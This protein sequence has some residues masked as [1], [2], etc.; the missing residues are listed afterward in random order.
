MSAK[1]NV[2][3]LARRDK[4][5]GHLDGLCSYIEP[6]HFNCVFVSMDLGAG[7]PTVTAHYSQD[8]MYRYATLEGIGKAPYWNAEDVLMI[9]DI[10]LMFMSST[11]SGKRIIREAWDKDWGGLSFT[12]Q[13][14]KSSKAIK[15]HLDSD[16]QFFKMLAL[17]LIYGMG[18]NRLQKQSYEQFSV[19]LTE[20]EAMSI[21]KGYWSTFAGVR[22]LVQKMA[23]KAKQGF[24]I[25]PFGYRLTFDKSGVKGKDTTHKA[26]N[27]FIQSCVS[28]IMHLY[29]GYLEEECL[30]C[31][32]P[33]YF[34]TVIHDETV[35]E[36][37][38]D[39]LDTFKEA[40]TA[41][42]ERLN[43]LLQ[44][45]VPITIGLSIGNNFKEIK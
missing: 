28:G 18:P 26:C 3:G 33:F 31:G 15:T 16:R 39:K 42:T 43:K 21:Y 25:N 22:A 27:Y 30:R 32:I 45:S 37:P 12:D 24:I 29:N 35:L 17:A 2:Q 20:T 4:G 36:V 40:K 10:Y 23:Q 7:E 38:K 19:E 6:S 1:L 5:L 8:T 9:D 44:W 34:V 11:T 14:L 41:A 13:W